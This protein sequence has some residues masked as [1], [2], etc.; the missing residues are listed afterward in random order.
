LYVRR[1][2][3]LARHIGKRSSSAACHPICLRTAEYG[4]CVQAPAETLG[5]TA[6][7]DVTVEVP[8]SLHTALSAPPAC[9]PLLLPASGV[10]TE[11]ALGGG[12]RVALPLG[13]N[14]LLLA[15]LRVMAPCEV[16]RAEFGLTRFYRA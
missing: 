13:C 9:A 4:A 7:I 1:L 15:T 8:F 12:T 16:G 11:A 14:C 10:S 2:V 6:G 3:L 5:A